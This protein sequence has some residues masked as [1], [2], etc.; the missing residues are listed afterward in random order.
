MVPVWGRLACRIH[1]GGW[2]PGELRKP[3]HPQSL[4]RSVVR[5]YARQV[6]ITLDTHGF[7]VHSLRANAATTALEHGSDI[8]RVQEW[9]RHA[10]VSTTRLYDKRQSRPEDSPTLAVRY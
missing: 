5:R 10:N 7:C 8:A 4:Y 1:P 3:L 2:V 6:G 9:L